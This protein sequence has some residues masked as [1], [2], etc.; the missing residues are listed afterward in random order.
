MK[1]IYNFSLKSTLAILCMVATMP[2]L[3]QS[4]RQS[5]TLCGMD[6]AGASMKRNAGL[7]TVNMD[8]GLGTFDLDGNRAA[9]FAPVIVNGTDT[10]ALQPVGLY[11]RTRWYQ[12]L[13]AGEK[14][15][16]GEAETSLRW[17]ERPASM[18]YSQTIP[19]AEWMDGA[20]L[21]LR[22]CD[23]GCCRTLISEQMEP[24]M[25]YR[26]LKYVPVFHYVRPVGDSLKIFDL[27]GSAYI[28]FPVNRTELYPE[29]RKNPVELAKIIATIDSVRSD[30]DVT[31]K[32]LTIKGYASPESPWDNNTRLAKGRTAT[33][34]QYVQNLYHFPEGFILTDYEPEDWA[35]L[36]KFVAASG[37]EHKTEILAII[38]D[39]TL[40]PDPREDKLKNTYP[41]EYRFLLQT[42]YPGLRHSDYTIEYTIREF[43][44]LEEIRHL[45]HTAPQKLSQKEM[46]LLAQTMEPGS[47]EYNEVFEIAVKMFPENETANLN[48]ANAAMSRG[49]LLSAEKYLAKAGNTPEVTYAKGILAAQQG[50]YAAAE[51]LFSQVEDEVPEAKAALATV[52]EMQNQ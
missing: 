2:I 31:V 37:L 21:Y 8:L 16:G 44:D 5:H 29:Y 19:Y 47:E 22:R 40:E 14:P 6:V 25:A 43:T 48:A 46:F 24:L 15:L 11:S 9:V 39:P 52:K 45:L 26:E 3:A 51:Q 7:M 50:N 33:L 4:F 42:V 38:D 1:A 18:S 23:Y 27:S 36:R 30:K 32:S 17:S 10:L 12:Y 35:G 28:D 20:Q 41:E 34:K 49:D 13:R